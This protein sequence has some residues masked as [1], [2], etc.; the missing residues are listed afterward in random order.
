M[1][2][3]SD[4]CPVLSHDSCNLEDSSI[5]AIPSTSVS[6]PNP[7]VSSTD[8]ETQLNDDSN[9]SSTEM[10]DVDLNTPLILPSIPLSSK[11]D[12]NS[13]IEEEPLILANPSAS[14]TLSEYPSTPDIELG[15]SSAVEAQETSSTS[16]K[17][18]F[19]DSPELMTKALREIDRQSKIALICQGLQVCRKVPVNLV[20][21]GLRNGKIFLFDITDRGTWLEAGL[22]NLLECDSSPV[23][24]SGKVDKVKDKVDKMKRMYERRRSSVDSDSLSEMKFNKVKLMFDCRDVSDSL[25]HCHD[26]MLD[27]VLDIQLLEIVHRRKF[28][29]NHELLR[30]FEE[31]LETY[32]NDLPNKFSMNRAMEELESA[33]R[34]G[35]NLWTVQ[36]LCPELVDGL[37]AEVNSLFTLYDVLK[38]NKN[39]EDMNLALQSSKR[40]A[41]YF[42]SYRVFPKEEFYRNAFVPH[43]ILIW[44]PREAHDPP[45]ACDACLKEFGMSEMSSSV[46]KGSTLCALC[47]KI[48][49]KIKN[50]TGVFPELGAESDNDDDGFEISPFG[51]SSRRS[52]ISNFSRISIR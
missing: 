37:I 4:R 43:N 24:G 47:I 16:K 6:D 5:P 36:P 32:A 3:T 34:S 46:I 8:L 38:R 30:D 26:V 1:E 28:Y 31:C 41:N 27:G 13:L 21:V 7:E 35:S 2:N 19:V 10:S 51:T 22:K 52:S 44:T 45:R 11:D 15:D 40:Y 17:I 25:L 50:K 9:I 48:V 49:R 39:S 20:C 23:L 42:R 14:A 12:V 18:T 29:L 33:R